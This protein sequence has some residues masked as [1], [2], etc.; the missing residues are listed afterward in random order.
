VARLERAFLDSD[1]D[2]GHLA[3]VLIESPE[4]WAGPQAKIKTPQELMV[5]A[6]RVT[7]AGWPA[8]RL[9]G[10]LRQLG[11]MPFAAPSPAGW[12]DDAGHWIGPE[13][14]MRRIA[15]CS[16]AGHRLAALIRPADLLEAAIGPVARPET[17]E[18]VLQAPS[19]AEAVTLVLASP[20]FQRR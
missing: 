3:R 14:M 11:Q 7:G 15:W 10:Q 19:A 12:P 18:A 8:D 13:A 9:V 5:S 2:L 4:A 16:L 1:G 6:L 20:E 17:R